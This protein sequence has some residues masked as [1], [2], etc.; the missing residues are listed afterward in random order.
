MIALSTFCYHEIVVL[1]FRW[2]LRPSS[3]FRH[4]FPLA[5][6]LCRPPNGGATVFAAMVVVYLVLICVLFQLFSYPAYLL[7]IYF[8]LPTLFLAYGTRFN[9]HASVTVFQ[10]F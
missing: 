7:D 10:V 9:L 6:S 4:P 2:H 1:Y 3:T 8:P 5:S